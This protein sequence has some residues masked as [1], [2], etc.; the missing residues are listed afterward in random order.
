MHAPLARFL[1]RPGLDPVILAA[2]AVAWALVIGLYMLDQA[3]VIE[4]DAVLTRAGA[5]WPWPCSWSPGSS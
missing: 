2:V 1:P 4:H 5:A 3:A